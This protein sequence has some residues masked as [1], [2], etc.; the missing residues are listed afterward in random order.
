VIP[1]RLILGS[2]S[3]R[4]REI[5]Q[6]LRIPFEVRGA[7]ANEDVLPG[8]AADRYLERVVAAKLDAVRALVPS[9][10]ADLILVADTTVIHRD[11]IMGKPVDF[12][13]ASAMIRTL[14]GQTHEVKT[15]FAFAEVGGPVVHAETVTTAVTFRPLTEEE[16]VEYAGSGEGTDKAGGYGAQGLGSSL[17]SRI[18]GSHSNVIGLP[19]CEVFVAWRKYATRR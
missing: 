4:R 13:E 15:R 7:N 2:T 9:G 16:I 5:L 10:S 19:A 12:D 11:A 14:A 8:E 1:L 6:A 18:E 3:P 17:V